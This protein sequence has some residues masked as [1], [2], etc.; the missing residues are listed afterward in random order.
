MTIPLCIKHTHSHHFTSFTPWCDELLHNH[1]LRGHIGVVVREHLASQEAFRPGN[2]EKHPRALHCSPFHGPP[3]PL[4]TFVMC[5]LKMGKA[6]GRPRGS[7]FWPQRPTVVYW[8]LCML[9]LAS[10]LCSYV[11]QQS[12]NLVVEKMQKVR[13]KNY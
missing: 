2:A 12:R 4:S 1:L 3:S 7:R 9:A 10:S 6:T 8:S 13:Y 5:C 11:S